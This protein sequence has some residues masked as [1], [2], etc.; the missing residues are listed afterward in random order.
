MG[1]S[2]HNPG[3]LHSRWLPAIGASVVFA[4]LLY[5]GAVLIAN[6]QATW[7]SISSMPW[8]TWLLVLL[9]SLVN[10]AL[11]FLR[12]QNYLYRLGHQ[13]PWQRSGLIYLGGFA[14][15][16]SPGKA[17]EALRSVYLAADGVPYSRSLAAFF[18][19]RLMDTFAMLALA[20]L[21][22]TQFAQHQDLL[23]MMLLLV[24]GG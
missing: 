16:T 8:Q 19:E 5:L 22:L 7:A 3:R 12:W 11:R 18:T 21:V 9:L 13:V 10:Y 23:M 6:P 24:V 15:T 1:Y 17:G 14:L 2:P 20:C 4:V